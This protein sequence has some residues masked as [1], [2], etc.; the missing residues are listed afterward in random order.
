MG[1]TLTTKNLFATPLVVAEL[2]ELQALKDDLHA[3]ILAHAAK[4]P[5]VAKSNR[6]GWQ[7]ADDFLVWGGAAGKALVDR[8]KALASE[9]SFYQDASGSS[10]KAD[11][12]VNA[13][14][15]IS[16]PGDANAVHTH[17]GAFWS[18]VYYVHFD[19]PATEGTNPSSNEGALEL[20]DPRGA[21]PLMFE[22]RLRMRLK[23][24]LSAGLSEF[25]HPVPGQLVMFPSWLPHAVVPYSGADGS[26]RISIAMNLA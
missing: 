15:N 21:L 24:Y 18:A 17:P 2:P 9:I 22:P 6:G 5:S 10:P 11:W 8:V 25:H 26:Q 7:S 16:A 3:G 23:G 20:L 12:R 4:H 1:M 14:A 13:W 19:A